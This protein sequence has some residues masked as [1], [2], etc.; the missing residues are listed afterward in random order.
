MSEGHGFSMERV[1]F[2]AVNAKK[3]EQTLFEFRCLFNAFARIV[4]VDD[5]SKDLMSETGE[6]Y[7]RRTKTYIK[8]QCNQ[9]LGDFDTVY[10]TE[11]MRPLVSIRQI[12]KLLRSDAADKKCIT[13][14]VFIIIYVMLHIM[15]EYADENIVIDI[16]KY[17]DV[18]KKFVCEYKTEFKGSNMIID[19]ILDSYETLEKNFKKTG[20]ITQD[21][22]E[23]DSKEFPPIIREGEGK[24]NDI[25]NADWERMG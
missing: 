7:E 9:F 6:V 17:I 10:D 13:A 25:K 21:I 3:E 19:Y 16:S 12:S 24:E 2:R 18:Y 5:K 22:P 14:F 20:Y 15:S 1:Y 8:E 11:G 4:K 23:I